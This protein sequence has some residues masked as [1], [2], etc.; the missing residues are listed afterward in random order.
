M[1]YFPFSI[2]IDNTNEYILSLAIRSWLLIFV[3]QW[4]KCMKTFYTRN[5]TKLKTIILVENLSRLDLFG[6]SNNIYLV[7]NLSNFHLLWLHTNDALMIQCIKY[8]KKYEKI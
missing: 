3:Q 1:N 8:Y 2:T 6:L 4:Q 7:T 5:T